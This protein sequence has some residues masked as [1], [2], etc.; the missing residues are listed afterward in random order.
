M[1]SRRK[2][3]LR[4]NVQKKRAQTENEDIR[5]NG[6]LR[7]SNMDDAFGFCSA[8]KTMRKPKR[9]RRKRRRLRKKKH[10]QRN[11]LKIDESRHDLAFSFLYYS[12]Y[13]SFFAL[14]ECFSVL[15][16]CCYKSGNGLFISPLLRL[17][18]CHKDMLWMRT[19]WKRMNITGNTK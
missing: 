18:K 2:R 5:E 8:I 16:C 1:I 15:F 11:Q 10:N 13:V 17:H 4:T 14:W 12:I 6:W 19:N 3:F 9:R 7:C